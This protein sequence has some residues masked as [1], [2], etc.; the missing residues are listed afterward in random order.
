MF[1]LG[2][3]Y[4]FTKHTAVVCWVLLLPGCRTVVLLLTAGNVYPVFHLGGGGCFLGDLL[5]EKAAAV[6]S[7]K[8]KERAS[9]LHHW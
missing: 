7:Y 6:T 5:F 2:L 8:K 9:S 4:S 3:E 1:F